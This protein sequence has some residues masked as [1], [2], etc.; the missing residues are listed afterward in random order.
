MNF[1]LEISAL[2]DLSTLCLE[3]NKRLEIVQ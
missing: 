1:Q 3:K 2:I